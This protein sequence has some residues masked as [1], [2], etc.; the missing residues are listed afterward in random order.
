M[1]LNFHVSHLFLLYLPHKSIKNIGP[2]YIYQHTSIC[3]IFCNLNWALDL[4][5]SLL[6]AHIIVQSKHQNPRRIRMNPGGL[7]LQPSAALPIP[8]LLAGEPEPKKFHS[9]S[10]RESNV[11]SLKLFGDLQSKL[12]SLN[13]AKRE[14]SSTL[15]NL[16]VKQELILFFSFFFLI[17]V[18]LINWSWNLNWVLL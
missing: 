16:K 9:F 8:W 12:Q 3:L 10:V 11:C 4:K 7:S 2:C 6:Q 14:L 13:M 15:K 18:F 1:N 17:T 5:L